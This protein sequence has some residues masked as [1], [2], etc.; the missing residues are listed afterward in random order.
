MRR[1]SINKNCAESN[2]ISRNLIKWLEV[3]VIVTATVSIKEIAVVNKLESF[4]PSQFLTTKTQ[5]W[6]PQVKYQKKIK[7]SNKWENNNAAIKYQLKIFHLPAYV[8]S[9]IQFPLIHLLKE[10]LWF[11]DIISMTQLQDKL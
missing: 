7:K 4:Q 6:K 5:Q 1:T 10:N 9:K 2:T 11:P 8:T 3:S